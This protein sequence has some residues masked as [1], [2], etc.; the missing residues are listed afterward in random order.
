LPVQILFSGVVSEGSEI[1]EA[2]KG[3]VDGTAVLLDCD[4]ERGEAIHFVL[5]KKFTKNLFR[6]Y[7]SKTGEGG[8]KRV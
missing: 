3:R 6:M 2:E 8:W 1:V 7:Y 5:R 4:D